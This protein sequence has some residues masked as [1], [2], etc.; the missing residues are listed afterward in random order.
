MFVHDAELLL[1]QASPIC[2]SAGT[3]TWATVWSTPAVRIVRARLA[4]GVA[5]EVT[6]GR[7]HRGACGVVINHVLHDHLRASMSR[8]PQAP[9]TSAI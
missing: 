1:A 8:H 9:T 5:V 7:Q 3:I 6:H 2:L 4:Y